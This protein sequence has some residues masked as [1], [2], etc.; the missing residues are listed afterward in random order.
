MMG[1]PETL[2]EDNIAALVDLGVRN[3]QLS[4]DGLEENHDRFRKDPGTFRR[5]VGSWLC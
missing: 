4:L 2:T 5:T 1:N 3:Y